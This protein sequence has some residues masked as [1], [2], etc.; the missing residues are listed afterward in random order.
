[1]SYIRHFPRTVLSVLARRFVTKESLPSTK[2]FMSKCLVSYLSRAEQTGT[3]VSTTEDKR[4]IGQRTSQPEVTSAL[5]GTR[6]ESMRIDPRTGA[7]VKVLVLPVK[8]DQIVYGAVYMVASMEGTYT[9][10]R[11]MNG[12]LATGTMFALIITA[13][14]GVVLARTITKPVKEMTRQARAVADGEAN[15]SRRHCIEEFEN[16]RL[17]RTGH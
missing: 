6:S 7:R 1:M 15:R 10:I 12:I 9:T 13:G 3:V 4:T 16:R 2:R 5:L 11:K 17:S 8:G 14:L